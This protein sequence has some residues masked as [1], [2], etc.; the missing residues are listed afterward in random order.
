MKKA[1]SIPELLAGEKQ[2]ESKGIEFTHY[3]DVTTGWVMI[4]DSPSK[5]L[6]IIYLGKCKVDGDMF[7][8]RNEDGNILIY[9]GHLN[10]G[11]Y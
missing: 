1:I 5:Y 2:T 9:K 4:N 11:T 7:Y 6:N 10:N 8:L 3:L